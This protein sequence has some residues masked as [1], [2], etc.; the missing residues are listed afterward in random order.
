[1]GNGGFYIVDDD[2]VEFEPVQIYNTFHI[3][4]D[5][6]H[7]TSDQVR[8]EILEQIKGKEFNDTI[9]TIESKL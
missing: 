6:N 4:I 8:D 3:K 5:A 9:V 7:K 2:K 1:M